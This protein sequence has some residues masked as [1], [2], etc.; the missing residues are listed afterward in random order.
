MWWCINSSGYSCFLTISSVLLPVPKELDFPCDTYFSGMSVSFSSPL[1]LLQQCWNFRR[2]TIRNCPSNV[3]WAMKWLGKNH[4]GRSLLSPLIHGVTWLWDTL[5][6]LALSE[7]LAHMAVRKIRNVT[8]V[9]TKV[10]KKEADV[11]NLLPKQNVIWKPHLQ[12]YIVPKHVMKLSPPLW[13]L[14]P[15]RLL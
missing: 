14:Q 2:H 9:H 3:L 6:L 12:S 11:R 13:R 15:H 10:F 4:M 7:F 5:G 1:S 8:E